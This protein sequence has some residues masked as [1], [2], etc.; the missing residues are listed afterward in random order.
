[1]TWLK[2]ML[3]HSTSILAT[4]GMDRD[5]DVDRSNSG[6]HVKATGR[7]DHSMLEREASVKKQK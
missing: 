1:M 7:L 3:W 5:I 4:V 2:L 6:E